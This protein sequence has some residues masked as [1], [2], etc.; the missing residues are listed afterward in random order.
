MKMVSVAALLASSSPI[1]VMQ[2]HAV[3]KLLVDPQAHRVE[4]AV[5]VE[6]RVVLEVRPVRLDVAG[7]ARVT[8]LADTVV[9]R[10][11]TAGD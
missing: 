5:V 9:D 2:S 7:A 10:L 11:G 4:R 8:L 6:G 1:G 3:A